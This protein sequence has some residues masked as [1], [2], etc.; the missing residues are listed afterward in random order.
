MYL[1]AFQCHAKGWIEQIDPICHIIKIVE[2]N[3][4]S[5]D[6]EE[7]RKDPPEYADKLDQR[8]TLSEDDP[9]YVL[10]TADGGRIY[11]KGPF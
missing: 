11:M 4:F 3:I 2:S 9:K 8:G 7:V 6:E 10:K 5:A 1:V